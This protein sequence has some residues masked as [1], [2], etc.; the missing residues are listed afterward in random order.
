M[1]FIGRVGKIENL[2]EVDHNDLI[3]TTLS[4]LVAWGTSFP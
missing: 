1:V 4:S 2:R 3:T